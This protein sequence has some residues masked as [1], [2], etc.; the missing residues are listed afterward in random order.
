LVAQSFAT[1]P[2][3]WSVLKERQKVVLWPDNDDIG[4]TI[5]ETIKARFLPQAKIIKPE[6]IGLKEKEDVADLPIG[7]DFERLL[8]NIVDALA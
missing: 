5:M 1:D 7:P 8:K 3:I 4:K 2:V 6:N